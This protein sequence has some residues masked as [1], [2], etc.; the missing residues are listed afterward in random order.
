ML[1]QKRMRVER[2]RT[3]RP[4]DVVLRA[5]AAGPQVLVAA[6]AQVDALHQWG[7][8]EAGVLTARGLLTRNTFEVKEAF[9]MTSFI[10]SARMPG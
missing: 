7:S 6:D 5:T 9:Q 10:P 8:P 1:G 2:L 4:G 3:L